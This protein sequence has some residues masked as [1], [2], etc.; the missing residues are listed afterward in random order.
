M[1]KAAS[2]TYLSKNIRR[3]MVMHEQD[4]AAMSEPQ[5]LLMTAKL[6]KDYSIEITENA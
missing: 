1:D 5:K 4:L 3:K 2:Y 6:K